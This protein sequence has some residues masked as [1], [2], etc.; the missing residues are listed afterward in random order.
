MALP[1]TLSTFTL[2]GE[3]K[4]FEGN[5]LYGNDESVTVTY[6]SI[7][8]VPGAQVTLVP[9]EITRSL[10]TAGAFS[11]VIPVTNDPDVA[12]TGFTITVRENFSGGR[13][14]TFEAP[15]GTTEILISSMAEGAPSDVGTVVYAQFTS[16]QAETDA[17]TNADNALDSRV[18][19]LEGSVSGFPGTYVD[20]T[21]DES[22]GGVKTFTQLPVLPAVDPASDN[23]PARKAYVDSKSA[24]LDTRVTS[25]E[26]QTYTASVT[27]FLARPK[28][29]LLAHRG[30]GGEMPEHTLEAYRY[31]RSLG[32]DA[33]EISVNLTADGQLVCIHDQTVDRTTA[34]TGNVDAYTAV[35]FQEWITT[36]LG[37]MLGQGVSAKHPPL[38]TQ[39]LD[40]LLGRVTIFLEPKSNPTVPEL[41]ALLTDRYPDAPQSVVWKAHIGTS[42]AWAKANGYTTWGYVDT[43]TATNDS[44]V[45]SKETD[46]DIWGLPRAMS[47]QLMLD[48]LN[49]DGKPC[50]V[51]EVHR[52][53]EM[54]RL[55]ALTGTGTKTAIDGYMC[56]EPGYCNRTTALRSSALWTPKVKAPGDLSY[57]DYDGA[58]SL[59]YASD[60]SGAAW[61]A[62]LSGMGVGQYSMCPIAPG[63]NGYSINFD[64]MFPVLP[65]VNLHGGL[66]FGKASDDRYQ[67]SGS[68][69]AS[70]GY[71]AI[72]RPNEGQFQLYKHT[73]GVAA[74]TQLGTVTTAV[75]VA[76][77]WMSFQ[78]IVNATS[79]ELKR[80]DGV[81]WTTGPIANTEF[82]GLY[83]GLHNGSLTDAATIPQFRNL[84][85][86]AL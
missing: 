70:S 23:Q 15:D 84:S 64:M 62:A 25:L 54:A 28:P 38:L 56:S 10:D 68:S 11:L 43:T 24:A 4:D 67:F 59:R 45:V 63:A 13:K 69:N 77:T 57:N 19:S 44:T 74:G 79:V 5:P 41:Q 85:W 52:R 37:N 35:E 40:E 31:G 72:F 71:H 66:Y 36:D 33:V 78:I 16:L 58:T 1:A 48:W 29:W 82:R 32:C 21:S 49:R 7:V 81:G 65:A 22:I 76:G 42:F 83:F 3:Y 46:I 80:T 51:W 6:P 18:T 26:A 75:A 53:S 12:P 61:V 8:N 20:Q 17:R 9:R 86:T 39:V 47:D 30:G 27:D 73:A 2:R 60:A 34:Q 50:I 14:L 55:S